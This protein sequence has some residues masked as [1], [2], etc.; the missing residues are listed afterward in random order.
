M[1]FYMAIC[2]G[3]TYGVL[4]GKS[5]YI[6]IDQHDNNSIHGCNSGGAG[7]QRRSRII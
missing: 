7:T 6:G 5:K 3:L 1:V 2:I 4:V